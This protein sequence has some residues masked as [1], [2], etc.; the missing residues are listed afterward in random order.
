MPN[1]IIC[2]GECEGESATPGVCQ[3]ENCAKEGEQL[4]PCDCTDGAHKS[5]EQDEEESEFT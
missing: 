4:T 1:S 5:K 3:D 2:T